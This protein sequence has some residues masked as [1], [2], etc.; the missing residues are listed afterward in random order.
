MN[1]YV[2]AE[3][4]VYNKFVCNVG[5]KILSI[6]KGTSVILYMVD[7]KRLSAINLSDLK[8]YMLPSCFQQLK[9]VLKLFLYLDDRSK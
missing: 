4:A 6:Q 8:T 5:Q 1:C 9:M 2:G 3:K 7:S